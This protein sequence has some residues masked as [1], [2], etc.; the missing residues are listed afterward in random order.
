MPDSADELIEEFKKLISDTVDVVSDSDGDGLSDYHEE[1]I[2]LFNGIIMMLNK[3]NAD[4]DGDGLKDG[5]EIVQRT[6]KN[7]RVFFKLK[8]YPTR[9]DSDNDSVEDK[10]DEY[11]LIAKIYQIDY[12]G[13]PKHLASVE[14]RLEIR[15]KDNNIFP[16]YREARYENAKVGV[17]ILIEDYYTFLTERN[18]DTTNKNREDY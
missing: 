8:S 6:D 18:V 13:S 7:G 16:D 5:E 12:L 10:E 11:P 15:L 14:N 17:E 3:K 9:K 1:R 4:T 2:R